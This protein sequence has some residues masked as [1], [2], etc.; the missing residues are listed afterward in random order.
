MIILKRNLYIFIDKYISIKEVFGIFFIYI[1][2]WHIVMCFLYINK[3]YKYI[4]ISNS[5]KYYIFIMIYNKALRA[6]IDL[7]LYL[8][9]LI[10]YT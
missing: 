2:G 1:F 7:Y 3:L 9:F 10:I 4:Y 6:L 8:N 5:V